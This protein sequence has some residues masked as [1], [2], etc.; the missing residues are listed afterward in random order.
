MSCVL[1]MPNF[2][3]DDARWAFSC[4]LVAKLKRDDEKS[5][6]IYGTDGKYNKFR[7]RTE[8]GT[9]IVVNAHRLVLYI[10]MGSVN[11]PDEIQ[12]SHLCHNKA[13]INIDHIMP[14]NKFLNRARRTCNQ[15]GSCMGHAGAPPCIF[16]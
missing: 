5:C 2:T 14:E 11:I 10:K 12:S 1:R 7:R 13:C 8:C 15:E 4:L 9:D 6:L 16:E 3:L